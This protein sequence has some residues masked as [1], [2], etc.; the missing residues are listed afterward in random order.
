MKEIKFRAWDETEK[1]M[2]YFD[3]YDIEKPRTLGGQIPYKRDDGKEVY[4]STWRQP[5]MQFTG[6]KDLRGKEIY[7]NDIIT[8][9]CGNCMK[10]H[11]AEMVWIGEISAWGLKHYEDR[12]ITTLLQ[13]ID[14]KDLA[15]GLGNMKIERIIGNSFENANLLTESHASHS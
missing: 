10:E 12:T 1:L 8:F 13:P 15:R 14:H 7:E 6:I 5:I 4:F 2:H 11:V 9:R 3:L